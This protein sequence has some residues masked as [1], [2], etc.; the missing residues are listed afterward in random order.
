MAVY[1]APKTLPPFDWA[2]FRKTQSC[3][4]FQSNL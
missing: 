4:I 3:T 1:Q 2:Y